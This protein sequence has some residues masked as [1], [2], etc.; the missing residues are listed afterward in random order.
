[1]DPAQRPA[2]ARE[3]MEKLEFCRQQLTAGSGGGSFFS[4]L[5]Q[6]NVVRVAIAYGVTAWLLAQIATQIFPFFEIPNWGVRLVILVLGIG[7]PIALALAWAFEITPEGIVRMDEG[8][9][10]ESSRRRTRYTF[11]VGIIM[12]TLA[13]VGLFAFRLSRQKPSAAPISESAAAVSFEKSIAVLPLGES[14]RRSRELLFRRWTT[15]RY[16]D[17]RGK[18]KRVKGDQPHVGFAVPRQA[19]RA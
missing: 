15:G 19:C 11:T 1:V 3:L 4:Q 18:D 2:S 5:K 10:N 16:P 8:V 14:E 7:F 9:P 12:V 13:A 17:Q 6:R